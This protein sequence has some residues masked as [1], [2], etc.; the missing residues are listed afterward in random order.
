MDRLVSGRERRAPGPRLPLHPQPTGWTARLKWAI[1]GLFTLFLV[2]GGGTSRADSTLLPALRSLGVVALMA[3]F[4][5][6]T[7][8]GSSQWRPLAIF[9]SLAAMSVAIQL[10]PLPPA[11]WQA[12]P[13]RDIAKAGGKLVGLHGIW[14]SLSLTP[15]ETL[16][17]LLAL[18][19]VIAIIGVLR[20]VRSR[21][22][23]NVV[24]VLAVVLLISCLIAVLQI[25]AGE[26]S[27]L[28]LYALTTED[29]AVGLFANRNH[30]AAFLACGFPVATSLAFHHPNVRLTSGARVTALICAGL[31]LGLLL[32]ATGSR[33]GLFL[34]CLSTFL[35]LALLVPHGGRGGLWPFAATG[36]MTVA[37]GL[38]VM[39]GD[40]FATIRRLSI[41]FGSDLR[42]D[43][44][45]DVIRLLHDYFPAGAGY[46]SFTAVYQI[47]E[48]RELLS[49]SYLNAAHNDFLQLGI[50]GGLPAYLLLALFLVW[51]VKRVHHN[52][53]AASPMRH[54][55]ASAGFIITL[56]LMLASL[57][58][59]PLRT[60]LLGAVF[61]TGC[62]LMT[63][64][65]R[66][67]SPSVK[68][69]DD[70]FSIKIR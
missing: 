5:A 53:N 21:D 42:F 19:P 30:Q 45:G 27:P 43:T 64:D 59:Y 66:A 24:F 16:N 20:C 3:A 58:D 35:S 8:G 17:A 57:V 36:G 1:F 40:R 15:D 29:S 31:L 70:N 25:A 55:F 9:A 10:I 26:S 6:P 62:W 48:R 13:G 34:G 2:F 4:A 47:A 32:L 65:E 49:P 7:P 54:P 18:T 33:A 28:R 14:R 56:V 39:Y 63:R 11:L 68:S 60:P 67:R 37:I 22:Q 12:L 50:E 23:A 38:L 61:V 51:W 46:G 41:K 44:L 69:L 52:V